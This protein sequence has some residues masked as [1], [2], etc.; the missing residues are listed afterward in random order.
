MEDERDQHRKSVMSL[1]KRT[2]LRDAE[3]IYQDTKG[4]VRIMTCDVAE[5]KIIDPLPRACVLILYIIHFN[6]SITYSFTQD[7]LVFL[8]RNN[9][10]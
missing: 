1:A 2:W 9:A 3:K 8:F 5:S 7:V 6:I 10:A 4:G